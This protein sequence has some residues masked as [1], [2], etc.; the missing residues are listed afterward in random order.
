[1][2]TMTELCF[3]YCSFLNRNALAASIVCVNV[4]CVRLR[5][6]LPSDK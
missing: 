4:V 6:V 3:L 2:V 1:M 5:L